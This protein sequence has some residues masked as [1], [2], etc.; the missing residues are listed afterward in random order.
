MTP[1]PE[2]GPKL[3]VYLCWRLGCEDA[4]MWTL[5]PAGKHP[6]R[7]CDAHLATS[8]RAAGLPARVDPWTEEPTGRHEV[9][10]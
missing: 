6:I 2:R 1:R 3:T 7:C 10:S 5:A 4:P 9:P 8:L